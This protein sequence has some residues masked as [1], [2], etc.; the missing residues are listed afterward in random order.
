M[1]GT[2]KKPFPEKFLIIVICIAIGF[3]FFNDTSLALA[4]DVPNVPRHGAYSAAYLSDWSKLADG[5]M[6][7]KK[8]LFLHDF[9]KSSGEEVQRRFIYGAGSK[10]KS[11]HLKNIAFKI[12]WKHGYDKYNNTLFLI[13]GYE[14]VIIENIAIIQLDSDYRASH[15]ILLEDC[16]EVIIKNCYFSGTNNNYHLRIEGCKRVF[17]DGI[18]IAGYDYGE[19]G[20]RCGGGILINNGDPK[21]GGKYGMVSPNPMD[22][23]WCVVQDCYIHGAEAT[24]IKRNQDGINIQ[25]AADGIVFNCYFEKWKV[26]DAALDVSHRRTDTEYK[27]HIFRIERNKFIDCKTVKTPGTSDR[28]CNIVFA[29]NVYQNTYLTDYHRGGWDVYHINETFSYDRNYK[30]SIFYKTYGLGSGKSLFFNCV[31]AS[32][33]KLYTLFFWSG[34]AGLQDISTL[35]IDYCIYIMPDPTYWVQSKEKK[36]TITN[37]NIWKKTTKN[38]THSRKIRLNSPLGNQERCG[39]VLPNIGVGRIASEIFICSSNPAL[40]VKRDFNGTLR[41]NPPSPGAFETKVK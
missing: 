38:D 5:K 13:R 2:H 36:V 35:N 18:E 1:V 23:Q 37:F 39:F 19:L 30:A 6:I 16:N 24:D 9:K 34:K 26:N 12:K 41:P 3:S 31:V 28:T 4:S 10:T 32:E 14:K 11:F 27:N 33:K 21:M 17:I 8:A 25:S 7:A 40:R 29:N 15:G 20:V 22:M